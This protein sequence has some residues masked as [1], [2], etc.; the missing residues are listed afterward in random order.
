M[1]LGLLLQ[2]GAGVSGPDPAAWN[3][4]VTRIVSSFGRDPAPEP[5][6]TP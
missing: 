5:G 2:R 1:H 6:R 4:L 3:D